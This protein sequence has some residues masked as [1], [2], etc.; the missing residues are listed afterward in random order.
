MAGTLTND[1]FFPDIDLSALRDAM[2]LD[3]T[4]AHERLRHA[5]RDA[6]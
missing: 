3:G 4:V 6:V 1:G 5:A 2:R